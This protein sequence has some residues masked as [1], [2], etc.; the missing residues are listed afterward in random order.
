MNRR[1]A[2]SRLAR[3][4]SRAHLLLPLAGAGFIIAGTAAL[5]L[6]PGKTYPVSYVIRTIREI[7][8][9][10]GRPGAPPDAGML[11]PWRIRATGVDPVSGRFD[12]FHVH[13]GPMLIAAKSANVT[14][15]PSADTFSIEMWDV[16]FL[17]V[18]DDPEAARAGVHR[19]DYHVLGPA[20]YGADIV[21]D[22]TSAYL[23][24][25]GREGG[26][27]VSPLTVAEEAMR[28]E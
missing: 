21:A 10:A 1:Q 11:G 12:D 27:A 24:P 20:P 16:V 15:D 8:L 2:R 19:L 23:A 13:C 18:P 6:T 9:S 7:A 4:A 3:G 22:G 28:G 17:R 5:L 14:V 26:A 25:P